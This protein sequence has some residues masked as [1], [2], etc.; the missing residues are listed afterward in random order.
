MVKCEIIE[1]QGPSPITVANTDN[2]A[3]AESLAL[4]ECPNTQ[5]TIHEPPMNETMT[6]NEVAE[7]E[8]EEMQT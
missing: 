5:M 7:S 2:N 1:P 6:I 4:P 3:A 8:I